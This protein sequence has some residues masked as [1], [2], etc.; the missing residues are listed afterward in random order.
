MSSS[1][2]TLSGSLLII[3]ISVFKVSVSAYAVEFKNFSDTV[4]LKPA[5]NGCYTLNEKIKVK[6][7]DR[8]I[9]KTAP[10]IG[11]KQIKDVDKR[12][13]QVTELCKLTDGICYSVTIKNQTDLESVLTAF[14]TLPFVYYS[15]PDLLQ[16]QER[17]SEK[18]IKN[19][20]SNYIEK[21]NI[22]ALWEKTK[23]EN[24]KIAI[25]DDGFDLAHEDIKGTDLAFGYDIETRT[26]DPSPKEVVDTHGTQVAGIIFAR[27]NGIGIDGI[28]PEAKLIAIRHAD[29]WTS[30]TILGF[31]LA[32]VA[33]A[34]IINCS[35]KSKILLE[36][37]ADIL[38]DLIMETEE[39]KSIVVVFAAGN[40]AA[41]LT[42]NSCESALPGVISVGATADSG[43][44]LALSNY[45]K[46]VDINT[47]GRNILTTN[48]SPK[49]YGLFS[50][51]SAS[52]SIVSGVAALLLSE[53]RNM[54]LPEINNKLKTLLQR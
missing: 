46:N 16:L 3:L 54:S 15:Q 19:M 45:G 28:A 17:T 40:E 13:I 18:N 6:L 8:I 4:T 30:K 1:V 53:N 51:T 12:V 24:V 20:P 26:L 27:H 14:N 38:N 48:C 43:R 41:E 9:I 39:K 7:C 21:L 36:P 29:S 23:G 52:S 34:D 31:Y 50:G 10:Y 42:D 35:W 32:K 11:K 49:K 47:C 44:R 25:I 5:Q 37:I 2:V 33:G 22:K